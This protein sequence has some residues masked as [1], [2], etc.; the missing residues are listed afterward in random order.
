MKKIFMPAF[1]IAF[2]LSMLTINK[3]YANEPDSAYIFAYATTK[4]NN[5]NG[6][7]FAWSLD[8]KEWHPI[9]PEHSYIRS[10]YGRWG[11]QKRM[12]SPF[13]FHSKDG[14]WHSVWT[15]NEQDGAFAH[16][17]SPDLIQWGRQSYPIV[18]E[19]GNC[20]TPVI[21]FDSS[22][23][24]YIISWISETESGE[25][26]FSV[27]TDNFKEY[28][29][30][31]VAAN[32]PTEREIFTI[33]GT[34]ETGTIHRVKWTTVK[35]LIQAQQL[36]AFKGN[37]NGETT[38][39]DATRFASLEPVEVAIKADKSRTREISD[40]L[41]GIFYEDINYAADG[42]L[43]AELVQ[44]RGFEYNPS[45]KLGSDKNWN[46]RKAWSVINTESFQ[47]DSISPVHPNN[48]HYA[49][50]QVD[51]KG[52]ALI[53][54]GF[55][56]IPVKSGEKYNFSVFARTPESNTGPLI[57]R[58][59]D[60]LGNT[61]A[62]S[63]T[64]K[65]SKNWVKYEVV[66]T[67]K[68]TVPDTKIS[69]EPQII[70]RVD[71]DMI[72]LFPQKTFKGRRNGMRADIAQTLADMKPTFVRFPGGC[73]AHGDGLDN[74]YHWK[75]TI[76]PLEERIP[77]RNIWN[78]HQSFG[79][80]Y[81]EYF[82]FCEDIG[83]QPI[84]IVAAGVPCQ[85]SGHHGCAI[86]GQQG[87]IPMSEMDAY[88]QD[89]LDLVEYANGDITTEW[90]RKR[91]EAGH[92][93]PFNLKYIGVG[94]EDLITD[95]FEE[96][97]TMIYN[98]LKE[99]H[100]EITVIGTVGPFFEGTD[101]VEGWKLADKLEIPIV[102]EHYYNPPGW[103]IHNQ[104][105]YDKYDRSKSKVY[106]GE[107]AAHLPGRPNNIESAL[108]EALHL[109]NVERNGDIVV[110]TSYAPLL[111]REGNTQWN[112]DLIYFNNTEVKPTV[113]Y[114]VQQL[115]G[116][117]IGDEYIFSDIKLSNNWDVVT[118]RIAKSIVRD[119]KTGDLI[120]KLVNLLPIEVKASIDLSEYNITTRSAV[121]TIL[122]GTP[123][124]RLAKPVTENVQFNG[125]D[126]FPPYSFTIIR[127]K[128]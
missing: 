71:L 102:D 97:F 53:N 4:N 19:N 20:L 30:A 26:T 70:G 78:Y 18:M 117:N 28:S 99:K 44:N 76:G 8:K 58:L 6:L 67:A 15:L 92:P 52:T 14:M 116:Q 46:S 87:G 112:P 49:V 56:G 124:D 12:I 101:Y 37:L 114:W 88:V 5:H 96:R 109:C 16:A 25:K 120:V 22:K 48:K 127:I 82:Q 77:Q 91:A 64:K 80:G 43:Y 55:D 107:Y 1:T 7:H 98:A 128:Q 72:S 100:P 113:G 42:G 3:M 29:K 119:S 51:K 27:T 54:E 40:M 108:T 89:V 93:K 33:S 47:I 74:I 31:T 104:D 126:T 2:L 105:F 39:E 111:A 9:G 118:K 79:L 121:K 66:L 60:K 94:N 21:S 68:E 36:S 23:N 115:F 61:V 85:N 41:M 38:R 35:E 50:L 73:V 10:D 122:T 83:A 84:P 45:D 62:E 32:I 13:V 81:F 34:K 57:I 11:S 106:L 110:M 63:R 65:L 75:H 103:Y 86:G 59:I 24:K 95:I 125:Q 123:D 69:I 17:S 90:G